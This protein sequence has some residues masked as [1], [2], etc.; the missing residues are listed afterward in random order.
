MAIYKHMSLWRNVPG[1]RTINRL[2]NK[3][4]GD[5]IYT[6]AFDKTFHS[7]L[8]LGPGMDHQGGW[9]NDLSALGFGFLG[10]DTQGADLDLLTSRLSRKRPEALIS[11]EILS[12]GS[13][14]ESM[15]RSVIRTFTLLYDF[16]DF[17][18]I[19]TKPQAGMYSLNDIS[20]L[21]DL[22]DE[23]LGIRLCYEQYRPIVLRLSAN[24]TGQELEQMLA[25]CRLSGIDAVSV[26][27][28]SL[29]EKV[30]RLTDG[31][32]PVIASGLGKDPQEALDMLRSGATLL[33]MDKSVPLNAARSF[34]KLLAKSKKTL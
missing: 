29:V 4:L 18:T 34:N 20:D 25:F 7:P 24:V 33:E 22:L 10:I 9:I 32:L 19:S 2:I 15:A 21:S 23:L 3:R 27:G 28:K 13:S 8:G 26:P 6:E 11:C 16:T 30:V 14:A 17:F 31:R 12:S 5:S 1:F